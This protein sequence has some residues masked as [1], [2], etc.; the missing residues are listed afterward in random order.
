MFTLKFLSVLDTCS[1]L[2]CLLRY[3]RSIVTQ[4]KT[5]SCFFESLG[6]PI[7]S[8]H[9]S[10]YKRYRSFF[11][12]AVQCK[13]NKIESWIEKMST[14]VLT[15]WSTDM[16]RALVVKSRTGYGEGLKM[17]RLWLCCRVNKWN[18]EGLHTLCWDQQNRGF[19]DKRA[20]SRFNL[21]TDKMFL[22]FERYFQIRFDPFEPVWQI[23]N[24]LKR[25]TQQK[26]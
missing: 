19:R 10:V 25:A 24:I 13:M 20:S 26:V 1:A 14:S 17:E 16:L 7:A 18:S 21:V 2:C 9:C 15:S 23:K 12:C 5:F 8:P 22:V 4:R 6:S 3:A 11:F